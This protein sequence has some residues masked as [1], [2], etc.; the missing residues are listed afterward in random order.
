MM[1]KSMVR[2]RVLLVCILLSACVSKPHVYSDYDKIHSFTS[3]KTFSWV[4]I[5]P[6]V[7]VG[8]FPVSKE[9]E[10]KATKTIKDELSSKGF[11]FIDSPEKADFVVAYTLGARDGIRTYESDSSVY[12]NRDNWLWG[13]QYH[14]HYF[15]MVVNE[16]LSRRHIKGVIAIDIFDGKL[17]TPVWHGKATKSL[18]ESEISSDGSSLAVAIKSVLLAFP[19]KF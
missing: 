6:L 18:D 17:K 1:T 16:D 12:E 14:S 10:A 3:Y 4:S 19:P 2:K 9:I 11:T 8:D 15:D 5:P 7:A 13:K